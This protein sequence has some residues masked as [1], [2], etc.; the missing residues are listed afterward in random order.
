VTVDLHFKHSSGADGNDTLSSIEGVIGSVHDDRI[1][2]H[3]TNADEIHGGDGDDMLY[4]RGGNDVLFGDAGDDRM[5][6]QN[7]D[8]QLDGGDGDDRLEGGANDD[9]LFGGA[10]NDRL[11]GDAGRDEMTGGL[12]SDTFVFRTNDFGGVTASLADNITDFSLTEGDRID[13][14]FADANSTAAGTQDF[15][16]I[17]SDNFSG[18]AG[19]LRF[20]Q[21]STWT[22]VSAD[23]DGDTTVDWM[24]RVEGTHNFSSSDFIF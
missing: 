11:F 22:E 19:Q 16:F 4:G 17:G 8:D 1:S 5:L 7:G 15:N 21:N 23:T 13:L 14:R 24:I 3:N 6:G 18:V 9:A 2:G 20:E 10:G 12:G